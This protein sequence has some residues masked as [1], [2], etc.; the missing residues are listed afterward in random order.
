MFHKEGYKIILIATFTVGLGIILIDSFV[1]IN[2]LNKLLA[3]CL[4]I[5]YVTILQFF[6]N[7]K[8]NTQLSDNAIIAPVDGK[9]VVIEE[10]FE[11]E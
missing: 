5:F 7:P 11:K 9:V 8:R 4:L 3:V 6:R 2:W 10:V 1:V